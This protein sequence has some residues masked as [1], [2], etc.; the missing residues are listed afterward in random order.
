MVQ[1]MV[2]SGA[3]TVP[4]QDTVYMVYYPEPPTTT[5]IKGGTYCSSFSGYHT[6]TVA[7][8]VKVSIAIVGRCQCFWP[9]LS[10]LQAVERTASHELMEAATNPFP[11]TAPAYDIPSATPAA[12]TVASAWAAA[13]GEGEVG[14]LCVGTQVYQDSGFLAQRIWSNV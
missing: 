10:V 7:N 14:D 12:S 8:G 3:V 9:G 11:D 13:I 2:T 4:V 1:T 6:E 5:L